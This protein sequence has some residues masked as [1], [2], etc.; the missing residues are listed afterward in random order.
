MNR[1]IR[2]FA[3]SGLYLL[4]LLLSTAVRAEVTQRDLQVAARA[5]NFMEQPFSGDTVMGIVFDPANDRSRN[6]AQEIQ[7][8]LGA[9]MAS[10]NLRLVPELVPLQDVGRARVNLFFLTEF[11]NEAD[12]LNTSRLPCVT[13][14]FAQVQNGNCAMGVRSVPN[15]EI[16]VNRQAA[17]L[18]DTEFAAVFRMMIREL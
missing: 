7:E 14:D 13:V 5:L 17:E 18:S 12:S 3:G 6:Q 4:L 11:L 15:V 10:G 16:V 2:F 9:G 8:M 1:I